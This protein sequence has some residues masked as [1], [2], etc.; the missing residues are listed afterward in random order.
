MATCDRCYEE[1]LS[2]IMSMFDTAM[3]CPACKQKEREHK[4]YERAIK[5]ETDAIKR[6]DYN[7]KGLG[8]PRDL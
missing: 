7:Y 4:D 8:R 5:A 3:I 1:T 6:G 2:T